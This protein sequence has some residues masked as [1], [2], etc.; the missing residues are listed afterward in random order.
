VRKI[1][2]LLAIL[3]VGV[4]PLA[5]N[6][7]SNNTTDNIADF[8]KGELTNLVVQDCGSCHG[9]TMRGGLG[10]ALLPENL[11]GRDPE[12]LVAI[13]LDGTPG[14]PM[15][16]WRPELSEQEVQ[17]IVRLLQGGIPK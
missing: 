10:P 3:T 17:W 5:L 15:P 7:M 13:I 12:D 16:P 14:T 9:L 1:L 11:D 2:S 8:R 4:V 6:A